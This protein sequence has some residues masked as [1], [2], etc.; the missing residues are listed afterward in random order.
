MINLYIIVLTKTTKYASIQSFLSAHHWVV[1]IRLLF[2][3][4]VQA[5]HLRIRVLRV[6]VRSLVEVLVAV[7]TR[8]NKLLIG[9]I[10]VRVIIL[11]ELGEEVG[12]NEHVINIFYVLIMELAFQ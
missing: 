7:I 2:T 3:V 5:S 1:E 6:Y 12:L 10:L 9:I 8:R 4:F 11:H